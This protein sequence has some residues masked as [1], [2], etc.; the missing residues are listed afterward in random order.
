MLLLQ[1]QA[2]ATPRLPNSTFHPFHLASMSKPSERHYSEGLLIFRQH[3]TIPGFVPAIQIGSI[4][5]K[6]IRRIGKR[7][8]P[9]GAPPTRA[10]STGKQPASKV[11]TP[12]E[13]APKAA[14][15]S[16]DWFDLIT[17]RFGLPGALACQIVEDL[18]D[19]RPYWPIL[20]PLLFWVVT[21]TY[22]HERSLFLAEKAARSQAARSE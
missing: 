5:I 17:R 19:L 15:G 9:A 16:A 1:P 4:M 18:D 2:R 13:P 10:A 8:A 14:R 11:A 12:T 20:L 3:R 6:R 21:S 22:R 7:P